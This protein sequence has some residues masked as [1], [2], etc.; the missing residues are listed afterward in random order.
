MTEDYSCAVI[1]L[2][3]DRFKV[4]NDSL[5]HM[6]GDKLLKET[7][8]RL[9]KCVRPG[10]TVARL[11]GDEFVMLCEQTRDVETAKAIAYRVQDALSD[12][13]MIEGSEIRC[14]ASIGIALTSAGLREAGRGAP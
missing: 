13:F 7:A 5:G 12:P 2:D 11:G 9:E 1:F 6:V 4:I 3:L 14:S 8:R 10:D